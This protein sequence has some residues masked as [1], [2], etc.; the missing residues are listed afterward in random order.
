MEGVIVWMFGEPQ[1]IVPD[2]SLPLLHRGQKRRD[3]RGPLPDRGPPLLPVLALRG[4]HCCGNSEADPREENY[5]RR[6]TSKL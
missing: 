5:R 1:V 2:L 6:K 4:L 3:R